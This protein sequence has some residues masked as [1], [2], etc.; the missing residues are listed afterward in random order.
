[1]IELSRG[2]TDVAYPAI[3]DLV[4]SFCMP[5]VSK[6]I[7]PLLDDFPGTS[8]PVCAALAAPR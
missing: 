7:I 3:H 2:G 6:P 1:M 5:V 8:L 4:E